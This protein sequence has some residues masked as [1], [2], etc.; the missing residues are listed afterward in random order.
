[1]KKAHGSISESRLK[2]SKSTPVLQPISTKP[3][4]KNYLPEVKIVPKKKKPVLETEIDE[5]LHNYKSSSERQIELN[6][7][8]SSYEDKLIE[9]IKKLKS[10]G[11]YSES[12]N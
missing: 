10:V 7:K 1:M 12:L 4:Y 2:A 6:K 11:G 3:E 8:Y 9:K 5:V